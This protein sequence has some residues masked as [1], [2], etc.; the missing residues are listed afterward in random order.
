M[1]CK[2]TIDAMQLETPRQKMPTGAA[3]SRL[4]RWTLRSVVMGRTMIQTSMR[5]LMENA[6]VVL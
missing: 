4:G 2:R 5:M 1:E 3:F 6:A